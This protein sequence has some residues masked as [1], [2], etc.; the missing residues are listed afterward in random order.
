MVDILKRE[1]TG[2]TAVITL[3]IPSVDARNMTRVSDAV[4]RAIPVEGTV[5]ID[6]SE[7]RYFDVIGF[8]AILSWVAEDRRKAEVRLCSGS[9]PVHA[10]FELLRAD[11]LIPLFSCREDAIAS[12]PHA[13]QAGGD[14]ECDPIPGQRIA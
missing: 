5:L 13:E 7:L 6:L 10:L 2:R 4:S 1:M 11:T 8:A 3:Q 14:L 9:G 12:F